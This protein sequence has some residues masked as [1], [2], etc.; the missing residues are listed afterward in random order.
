MRLRRCLGLLL[1]IGA[2]TGLCMV[3]LLWGPCLLEDVYRR[4]EPCLC[5]TAVLVGLAAFALN[6]SGCRPD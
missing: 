5:A 6:V 4:C 2:L 1:V 3:C